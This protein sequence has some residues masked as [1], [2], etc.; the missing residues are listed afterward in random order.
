MWWWLLVWGWYRFDTVKN[1]SIL[2]SFDSDAAA[3]AKDISLQRSPANCS[4]LSFADMKRTLKTLIHLQTCHGFAKSLLCAFQKTVVESYWVILSFVEDFLNQHHR[5]HAH[6]SRATT[7][8]FVVEDITL[9]R[10]P[11]LVLTD[12]QLC[13]AWIPFSICWP[14]VRWHP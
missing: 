12:D 1:G 14:Q 11:T 3:I 9:I 2:Q 5:C 8:V 10:C 4:G 13:K 6:R 7:W